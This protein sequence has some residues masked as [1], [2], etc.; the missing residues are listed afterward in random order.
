MELEFVSGGGACV[1][2]I[3]VSSPIRCFRDGKFLLKVVELQ[4]AC[5]PGPMTLL[6]LF[7]GLW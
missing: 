5:R 7:S 6:W 1:L 3:L 2:D 4:A